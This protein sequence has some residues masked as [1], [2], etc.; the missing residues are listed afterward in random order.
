M[1]SNAQGEL[2]ADSSGAAHFQSPLQGKPAPAFAL[3]D[4]NGKKVSLASYRRQSRTHQLL[5]HLVRPVQD[6]NALADRAAQ[7]VR[8]AG[9]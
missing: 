4:L 6:R 3:E 9:L 1:G 2:V 8:G 5:G 7:S